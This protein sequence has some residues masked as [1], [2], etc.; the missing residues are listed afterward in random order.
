M[1]LGFLKLKNKTNI[2]RPEIELELR[3]TNSINNGNWRNACISLS[4]L[5]LI[6]SSN[7]PTKSGLKFGMFDFEDFLFWLY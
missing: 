2:K 7:L 6:N 1:I 4:S 3:K 5:G